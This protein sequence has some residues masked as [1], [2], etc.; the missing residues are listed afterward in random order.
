M[1]KPKAIAAALAICSLAVI[2]STALAASKNPAQAVGSAVRQS[3]AAVRTVSLQSDTRA[4]AFSGCVLAGDV[5]EQRYLTYLV[6]D[7][8]PET[9]P[10]WEKAFAD[11]KETMKKMTDPLDQTAAQACKTNE[12]ESLTGNEIITITMPDVKATA[13][14]KDAIGIFE[15]TAGK[16]G[17]KKFVFAKPAEI[18]PAE[19]D[20]LERE[21]KLISDFSTAVERNDK[22]VITALL[23][24][25]LQNYQESTASL[26][27]QQLLTVSENVSCPGE[28]GAAK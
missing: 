16:D 26:A 15:V 22:V 2:G 27:R 25:L 1:K 24:Q 9:L 18:S 5:H 21:Q 17:D 11:R 8:A 4:F 7:C 19:R 14:E 23:P 20:K 28:H 3:A 12:P 10:A 6:T 13:D